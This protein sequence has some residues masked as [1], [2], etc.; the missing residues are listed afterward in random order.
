MQFPLSIS[1]A[2]L[3]SI[4]ITLAFLA[5]TGDRVRSEPKTAAVDKAEPAEA[6]SRKDNS[7]SADEYLDLGLPAADRP[8][9][10]NDYETATKSLKSLGEAHPDQLPRRGSPASGELFARMTSKQNFDLAKDEKFPLNQRL[11]LI[12]QYGA[13]SQLVFIYVGALNAG[14]N[15]DSELIDLTGFQLEWARL[16]LGIVDEFVPT[17]DKNDPSYAVRMNGLKTMKQG[18]AQMVDGCL[19]TMTEKKT[20]RISELVRLAGDM[21]E[22]LPDIMP[23]LLPASQQEMRKR[24]KVLV[25]SEK[26]PQLRAALGKIDAALSKPS[27]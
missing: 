26:D 5:A 18:L 2:A 23:Q 16:L 22:T 27:K 9:A 3:R 15:Y 13:S 10:G 4:L 12:L 14:E 8:W 11:G 7:L 20:Y 24:L 6:D 25:Q 19:V 1:Q 21:E 17:L